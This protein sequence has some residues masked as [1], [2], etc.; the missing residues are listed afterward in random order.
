MALTNLA[1]ILFIDICGRNLPEAPWRRDGARF[2]MD[3][4]LTR[5]HE[6]RATAAAE[7]NEA[8]WL[9]P[10]PFFRPSQLSFGLRIVAA[11]MS[12]MESGTMPLAQSCD[13]E[14][15]FWLM[16]LCATLAPDRMLLIFTLPI[17]SSSDSRYTNG[18]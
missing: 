2:I 12:M 6:F 18:G 9:L 3:S 4:A 13:L 1:C 8:F 17:P 5:P 14:Y 7:T 16:M 15:V 11:L 10:T